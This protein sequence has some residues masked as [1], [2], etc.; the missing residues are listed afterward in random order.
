MGNYDIS[1]ARA[2]K[3]IEGS[4]GLIS[5]IARRLE[6]TRKTVYNLRDRYATVKQAIEDE[7]ESMKDFAE[8]KLSEQI[9]NGNMTAI[10]FYLKT[11]AK[12]RGYTERHEF[13]GDVTVKGYAKFSP[14][15]WDD[16]A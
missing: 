6:C 1:A 10:I 16:D 12:D 15:D 14:D 9:K 4:G 11:Q 13:T 5:V 7:K 2:I 3:A 8:G